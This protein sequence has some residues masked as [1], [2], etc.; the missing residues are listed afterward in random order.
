MESL[1]KWLKKYEEAH[2]DG[3][4][5]DLLISELDNEGRE[6]AYKIKKELSDVKMEYY[7]D[8]RMTKDQIT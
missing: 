4:K 7:S 3:F 8:A 5:N 2:Y 1:R 6:I